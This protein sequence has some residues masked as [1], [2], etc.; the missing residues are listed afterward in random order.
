[1]SLHKI[2]YHYNTHTH[3]HT[4]PHDWTL[5][6]TSTQRSIL[7][8]QIQEALTINNTKHLNKCRSGT[9]FRKRKYINI[10]WRIQGT[11]PAITMNTINLNRPITKVVR[12]KALTAL[13]TPNTG[14]V[15]LTPGT[16]VR[17]FLCFCLDTEVTMSQ[18]H[19]LGV[20]PMD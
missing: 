12:S 10:C 13:T 16:Y 20:L 19:V 11:K 4:L 5:W 18:S 8:T 14:V 6:P 17:N 2:T 1:M 7:S 15:G 9:F 3:T